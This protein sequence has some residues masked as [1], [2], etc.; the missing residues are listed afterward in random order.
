MSIHTLNSQSL[1]LQQ[2]NTFDTSP[3]VKLAETIFNWHS[4]TVL[5]ETFL[6]LIYLAI[7]QC[8]SQ[9][10]I[11]LNTFKYSILCYYFMYSVVFLCVFLYL[12]SIT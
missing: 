2:S 7:Y 6:Y 10:W 1:P 11:M 9:P 4:S 12:L 8:Q 5:K 3:L